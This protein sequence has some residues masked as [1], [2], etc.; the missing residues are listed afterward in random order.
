VIE[1]I[2]SWLVSVVIFMR[3]ELTEN[4]VPV[5]ADT[6]A[7]NVSPV[8]RLLNGRL[9]NAPVNADCAG[10]AFNTTDPSDTLLPLPSRYSTLTLSFEPVLNHVLLDKG[11]AML[12]NPVV[13]DGTQLPVTVAPTNDAGFTST[14]TLVLLHCTRNDASRT[15]TETYTLGES[16]HITL[17]TRLA[18]TIDA[19]LACTVLL[20]VDCTVPREAVTTLLEPTEPATN[21]PNPTCVCCIDTDMAGDV[22]KPDPEETYTS[23]V[24]NGREL[25]GKQT[26]SDEYVGYVD[27]YSLDRHTRV[28]LHTRLDVGDAATV[29]NSREVQKRSAKQMRSEVSVGARASN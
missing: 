1:L 20:A 10:L 13:E 5:N 21:P 2:F 24:G 25:S 16:D 4:P 14:N 8:N 6:V 18:S 3:N 22:A 11:T 28:E 23:E 27:S 12:Q 15:R 29:S 26:R 19:A 17:L 7:V 9:T